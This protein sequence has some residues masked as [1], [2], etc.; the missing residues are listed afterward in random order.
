M[1]V[2]VAACWLLL[3]SAA[4][5]SAQIAARWPSRCARR[6]A[7]HTLTHTEGIERIEV[8]GS[9]NVDITMEAPQVALDP[10]AP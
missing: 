1:T 5:V 6:C 8:V 3:A 4:G 9:I 10:S 2:M 7:V